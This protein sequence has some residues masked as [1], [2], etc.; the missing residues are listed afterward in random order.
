MEKFR[1]YLNTLGPEAAQDFALRCDS[2]IGY[3]RK[4]ISEGKPLNPITCVKIERESNNA[5]TR[6]D[7][8]EKDWQ[9]VWP[10]LALKKVA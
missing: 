10:E 1:I 4:A 8:R 5:V 6:K 3:F 2:S 9:D 7:L